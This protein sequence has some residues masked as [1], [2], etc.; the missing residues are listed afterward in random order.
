MFI[1]LHGILEAE[2]SVMDIS[3]LSAL[4]NTT[5]GLRENVNLTLS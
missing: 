3:N 5:R 2:F 1:H 4:Y